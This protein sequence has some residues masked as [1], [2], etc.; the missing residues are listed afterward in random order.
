MGCLSVLGGTSEAVAGSAGR[1]GVKPELCK[2]AT[3][4]LMLLRHDVVCLRSP[5]P[6]KAGPA[7]RTLSRRPEG[8]IEGFKQGVARLESGK[9]R[10][11]AA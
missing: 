8:A 10:A 5:G 7:V 4:N 11:Q 3:S 9:L 2:G 1:G 6:R